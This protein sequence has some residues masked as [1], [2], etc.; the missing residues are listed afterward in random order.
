M[1]IIDLSQSP[2]NVMLD[3]NQSYWI[4]GLILS[5][6]R[7]RK[8][9]EVADRSPSVTSVFT[10]DQGTQTDTCSGDCTTVVEHSLTNPNQITRFQPN[11]T[12]RR[13]P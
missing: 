10:H 9:M 6:I 2:S 12:Q 8:K 7:T 3:M 13:R 4:K 11:R 1:K 5:D